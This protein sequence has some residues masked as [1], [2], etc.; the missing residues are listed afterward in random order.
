MKKSVLF[1]KKNYREYIKDLTGDSVAGIGERRHAERRVGK[2]EG[3]I[4]IGRP[5]DKCQDNKKLTLKNME[6][7]CELGSSTSG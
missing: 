3:K 5:K 2:H 6:N 1:T 7:A 4:T